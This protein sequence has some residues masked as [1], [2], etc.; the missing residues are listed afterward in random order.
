MMMSE[1]ETIDCIQVTLTRVRSN[2]K[3]FVFFFVG[4]TLQSPL[5]GFGI[6]ISGGNNEIDNQSLIISDVIKNGP[7]DGKLL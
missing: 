6:A 4:F 3:S 1:E 2:W 5:Y 7:A